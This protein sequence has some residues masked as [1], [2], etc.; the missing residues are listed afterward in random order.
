M[1]SALRDIIRAKASVGEAG[2]KI[3][4]GPLKRKDSGPQSDGSLI[5][6]YGNRGQKGREMGKE[7]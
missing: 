1:K 5:E 7:R 2:G 3:S 6:T 4:S